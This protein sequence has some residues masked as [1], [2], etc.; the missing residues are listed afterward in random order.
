[1]IL[2]GVVVAALATGVV[3]ILVQLRKKK[4]YRR[5]RFRKSVKKGSPMGTGKKFLTVLVSASV[6]A[7]S[8]FTMSTA[9]AD[10]ASD[11]AVS[12]EHGQQVV[13]PNP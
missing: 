9:N 12:V 11:D 4:N 8:S 7:T 5:F 2:I 3:A 6:I 10:T 13:E 1:M